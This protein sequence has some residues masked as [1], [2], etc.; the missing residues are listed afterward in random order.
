[1]RQC[2][3]IISV[4]ILTVVNHLL[5]AQGEEKHSL[6]SFIHQQKRLASLPHKT[7]AKTPFFTHNTEGMFQNWTMEQGMSGLFI[8]S[9][10]QDKSGRI[11][12]STDGSGIMSYDGTYFNAYGLDQGFKDIRYYSALCDHN[13]N[14]WFGS[15]ENGVS[16]FDGKYVYTL[17]QNNGFTNNVTLVL[18][19]DSRNRIWIGT[20]SEGL[21]CID[22]DSIKSYYNQCSIHHIR[23]IDEDEAGNIIVGGLGKNEGVVEVFNGKTFE[24]LK[25]DAE[26]RECTAVFS[27]SKNQ[28]WI[29]TENGVL[30][31]RKDSLIDFGM[32]LVG[33]HIVRKIS[34][35]ND[36]N[37]WVGTEGNGIGIYD[38]KQMK[39]VVNRELRSHNAFWFL[40][41]RKSTYIASFN[42]GL[43]K[44]TPTAFQNFKFTKAT[45]AI[46]V[47]D[48]SRI[49]LGTWANGGFIYDYEQN[50][51]THEYPIKTTDFIAAHKSHNGKI[52]VGTW[53]GELGYYEERKF[54]ELPKPPF[55]NVKCLLEIDSNEVYI[56][57]WFDGLW[58][59]QDNEYH[60]MFPNELLRAEINDLQL[61]KDVVWVAAGKGLMKIQEGKLYETTIL[62]DYVKP[63]AILIDSSQ[64]K[65]WIGTKNKGVFLKQGPKKAINFTKSNGLPNEYIKVIV[66]DYEDRIWVGTNKGIAVLNNDWKKRKA[67]YY[68]RSF[69]QTDGFMGVS[70]TH[71]ACID[72]H[73]YLWWGTQQKIVKMMPND[74]LD[75]PSPPT[76]EITDL[77]V[78]HRSINWVDKFRNKDQKTHIFDNYSP[79]N[80]IPQN[81]VLSARQNSL[82][83]T[84]SVNTDSDPDLILYSFKLNGENE[85]S[86]WSPLNHATIANLIKGAHTLTVRCKDKHGQMSN[87]IDFT[88]RIEPAFYETWYFKV[89]VCILTTLLF[90]LI[91]LIRVKSLQSAK[92]KL[93][94][95]VKRRTQTIK[96]QKET[97]E[98]T[99]AEI[100]AS[101]KAAKRLQSAVLPSQDRLASLFP[102]NMVYY[103]PK[104][105]LSGDFYW[106]SKK[107]DR[108]YAAVAD[109]TGHGIQGAML[110][111][112][113]FNTLNKV[114]NEMTITSPAEILEI[115]RAIIKKRFEQSESEIEGGMDITLLSINPKTLEAEWCGAYNN[116]HIV[117][118]NEIIFLK[119]TFQSVGYNTITKPFINHQIQL[120][121]RDQIFL[122]S[123]GILDQF[124]FNEKNQIKKFGRSRL[125][126][127][128][129]E[130][131]KH[132]FETQKLI[133]EN[134]FNNWR[135]TEDQ[136]DDICVFGIRI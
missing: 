10:I 9:V 106:V 87:S 77:K 99:Y 73:G 20:R 74:A 28:L 48:S 62:P 60:Q 2:Y 93:Q 136:I 94:K 133:I 128:Y 66:K 42:E 110:S 17:D 123:D 16:I 55:I 115:C 3:V 109:C 27:D 81:L 56:G 46:E 59:Y 101:I 33:K 83:F 97:L 76:I 12:M 4:L 67:A 79:F 19:E 80:F 82:Q 49:F 18:F 14:L 96:F 21:F 121:K 51:F 35:D 105:I 88:F 84:F 125:N 85:W 75:M 63:S 135:K 68:F 23:S 70:C 92:I 45:Y 113:C 95:E 134:T 100:T 71:G 124:G 40:H 89:I 34:E 1:M 44:Y 26:F 122:A 102:E 25:I 108:L 7:K 116:L 111:L 107:K 114:V 91:Y 119:G 50:I 29:G 58:K 131:S 117:R 78:K 13:G 86:E 8:W 47:M 38:G 30:F 32:S 65:M 64:N 126:K 52:W 129:L 53:T 54:Y 103:S 57:T 69:T 24:R 11:W 41:S 39:K 132:D 37:I 90:Y 104:A 112:V 120:E 36:G 15:H 31:Q 5:Y 127:L 61:H 130:I 118:D 22:G 72:K 6:P 98:E 43:I